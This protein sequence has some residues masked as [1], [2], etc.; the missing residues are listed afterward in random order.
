MATVS[1][2]LLIQVGIDVNK[3][4]KD[5]SEAKR[6]LTDVEKHQIKLVETFKK[7]EAKVR[8]FFTVLAGTSS[9]A[10]F[11]ANVTSADAAL[12]RL[13]RTTG[14]SVESISAWSNAAERAGGSAS[15]MQSGIANMS[16]ELTNFKYIGESTLVPFLAQ[17]GV[18]IVDTNGKLKDQSQI[19][20]E[21]SD[22]AKNMP[23]EDF[24]NLAMAN[25]F[26]QSQV[27]LML[28]GRKAL[29]KQIAEQ[30]KNAIVTKQ[31]AEEAAKAEAAWVDLKQSFMGVARSVAYVLIPPLVA[32]A[33]V[34]TAMFTFIGNHKETLGLLFLFAIPKLLAFNKGFLILLRAMTG[35]TPILKIAT[36]A[37]RGFGLSSAIA[38]APLLLI[39]AGLALL[40]DD[41]MTFQAGGDSLIPWGSI[42]GGAKEAWEDIK[43][44]VSSL[45]SLKELLTAI[46]TGDW[47]GAKK[48][49]ADI[50]HA[51]TPTAIANRMAGNKP[52]PAAQVTQPT[53]QAPA[54]QAPVTPPTARTTPQAQAVQQIATSSSVLAEAVKDLGVN[55][56]NNKSQI[57]Q[58]QKDIGYTIKS[59][60]AWCAAFVGSKLEKA[61]FKSTNS[62]SA[63]S[64]L[65]YGTAADMK[66]PLQ[67]GMVGLVKRKGGSGY[68][69][70]IIEKDNGDGTVTTIDGNWGNGVKRVTRKKS[71][72]ASVRV[73]VPASGRAARPVNNNTVSAG[74]VLLGGGSGSKAF[75][76]LSN[77]AKGKILEVAKNIGVNPNDLTAVMSFETAG[78]LSPNAR[79][80][81]SSGTGLIQFMKDKYQAYGLTRDKFGSLSF[82]QQ[83]Q[84]VERYF[85]ERGFSENKKQDVASLYTAV[86]GYG[87]KR[88]SKAYEQ[89]KVWD[90]NKDG[91]IAKGE[92]VQNTAFKAHQRNYFGSN[93]SFLPTV[94]ARAQAALRSGGN[95]TSNNV[96]SETH[97]GTLNVTTAVT[98]ARE[99][100]NRIPA[101]LQNGYSRLAHSVGSG[102][103]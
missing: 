20:L 72:F 86:T 40:F 66:K 51:V 34:L 96:H 15:E 94:G 21:L 42:F 37:M 77:S 52:P 63:K 57:M 38:L 49:G 47:T 10:A 22:R 39:G 80:P 31:Q 54:Q 89:N 2:F 33:K 59:I 71:D 35:I 3:I 7:G 60:D 98:N 1:E 65:N 99:F 23:K 13:S 87:Y 50:L 67:G 18:S 4:K 43:G 76:K 79:N 100:A 30:N 28:Q 36:F 102:M 78:T 103:F 53:A 70:D 29:E 19:M 9:I 64:Y 85:K 58:Y 14:M 45:G 24:S 75:D 41:F 69:V 5:A 97:I 44:L 26:N 68:H 82:E 83:M 32:V 88:G 27:N 101:E 17:M 56:K 48:A 73:P 12:G 93:A 46:A 8:A 62:P 61:G 16:K 11:I 91:Y 95:P 84:Y 81:G 6:Q 25:G 55:E 92:M 90:S 74:S